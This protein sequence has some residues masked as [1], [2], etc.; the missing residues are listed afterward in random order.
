ML[1]R[2]PRP[3]SL[4]SR[5]LDALKPP[6]AK[7]FSEMGVSGTAAYGGH[8]L[9]REKSSQWIGDQRYIT[10][11]DMAVNASIVAAGVH[12][13]LNLIA[14]PSWTVKPPDES[15]KAVEAAEFF[16]GI[17]HDMARPW[18]RVVRRAGTYRFF[19]FG[20][21]EWTA[22]RLED[23][24]VGLASVEPRPQ[25][26]IT[27]WALSESGEVD[28]VFQRDPQTGAELGLPRSKIVYLVE[29]AISDSP[30][31]LG[32]FRH[33]AE[34]WE[35]L[36]A[37]QDLEARAFERDLRGIP[38]GRVPYTALNEA[39][40]NG[41]V[42]AERAAALIRTIE[43][44]VQLQVRQS[45]TAITL[46]SAPYYSQA[47]DGAKVAAT[48]Q[49]G[50]E[51]LQGAAQGVEA[52]SA[53]ITRTQMEMARILT[54]EHLLMGGEGSGNRSLSEDKSRNLY[55]VANAVLADVAAAM[56]RDLVDPIWLLNGLPEELKPTLEVE[57][58]AFQD[59]DTVASTL[60]KMAT[61]GAVLAPDDPVIEDVRALMGV[62][63]P[64]PIPPEL[65][66][67][68]KPGEEEDEEGG[69]PDDPAE[70]EDEAADDVEEDEEEETEKAFNESDHPRH[71]AG[72]ERGG[73]FASAGGAEGGDRNSHEALEARRGRAV[74]REGHTY[75][76]ANKG[77]GEARAVGRESKDAT[78]VVLYRGTK[79]PKKFG[80]IKS[81][82]SSN[83]ARGQGGARPLT[84][85]E[86]MEYELKLDSGAR[87]LHKTLKAAMRHAEE[88]RTALRRGVQKRF[89]PS[90]P[91]HPRGNPLGGQ[92]RGENP[93]SEGAAQALLAANHDAGVTASDLEAELTPE[94]RELVRAAREGIAAGV[95][96]RDQYIQADG[97][98]S[99]EREALH[100]EI[101]EKIY[102]PEAVAAATPLPGER[103]ELVL[104][105]GRPAAGKT[106]SLRSGGIAAGP[107]EYIYVSA[108]TIQESLPGYSA[109]L[110]GLFNPEAQDIADKVEQMG[111]RLG[112]NVV[113]D[114]TMKTHRTAALRIGAY[115][116]AGY[117][118]SAYFVHTAPQTSARR[119]LQRFFSTGRFVPPEVS[120][121]SA[122]NE[123]TFD[124]LTP[125]LTRWALFDNNGD[126]PR[127]GPQLQPEEEVRRARW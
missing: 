84:M 11:T 88:L 109:P 86:T 93:S 90:Q 17:M 59:A 72:S 101:I 50:V 118:V 25:H 18:S 54:C 48:P 65:V 92:W 23:G 110:A 7:P 39:V 121:G 123:A 41:E 53:A 64:A 82:V 13:F 103:P 71:G 47:A 57:D 122:Q 32:I 95:P 42:T 68:S 127:L 55:L 74:A 94:Q 107:P 56:T 31:G 1:A 15:A 35:R 79:S 6:R 49:W 99:P 38:V 60:A 33:L 100:E 43:E 98:Y 44:F 24:R 111:R 117:D 125:E 10:I 104:T 26:T 106:S 85:R 66:G 112:V 12:Y 20:V 46:D 115:K 80:S 105:G 5:V 30:E 114:A 3:P 91:R 78:D 4:F 22:K 113:F 96:T 89:N 73:Q 69:A 87:F 9:T 124:S 77:H 21:Q 119:S 40:K 45:N 67:L 16:E 62:S 19:G 29:D 34:P 52:I 51:L 126:R 61:A 14:R 2:T 97:T 81:L 28:G 8:I 70:D 75:A 27:R 102:T 58:V 63:P 83:T 108:D 36:K 76:Y 120:L 116:A 37:Y